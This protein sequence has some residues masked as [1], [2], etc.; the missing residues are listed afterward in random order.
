MVRA[1]QTAAADTQTHKYS[2]FRGLPAFKKAI[3]DLYK[4]VL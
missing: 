3:A 2:P 4:R 1:L